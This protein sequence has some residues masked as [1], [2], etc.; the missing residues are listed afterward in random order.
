MLTTEGKMR[1]ATL[2]KSGEATGVRASVLSAAVS[3]GGGEVLAGTCVADWQAIS[4]APREAR[5]D[6]RMVM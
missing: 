3:R 5:A 4:N 6:E 1:S 2:A